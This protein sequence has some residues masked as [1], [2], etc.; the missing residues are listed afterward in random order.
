MASPYGLLTWRSE[1]PGVPSPRIVDTDA[2]SAVGGPEADSPS[3]IA[4]AVESM[5]Y[6]PVIATL[7]IVQAASRPVY[8]LR[9][10]TSLAPSAFSS[11]IPRI[12]HT[13]S[14]DAMNAYAVTVNTFISQMTFC[15]VVL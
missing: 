10:T 8:W 13:G 6:A 1:Y 2:S 9:K 7:A 15:P 3:V 4:T 12:L 5:A 14:V 11:Q